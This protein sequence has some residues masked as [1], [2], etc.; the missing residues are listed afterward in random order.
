MAERYAATRPADIRRILKA[1]F[2]HGD[3]AAMAVIELVDRDPDAKGQD[4]GPVEQ[5]ATEQAPPRPKPS[6]GYL[7]VS[8]S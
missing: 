1:G 3:D 2:R 7:P 8:R 6:R 5:K 4:S